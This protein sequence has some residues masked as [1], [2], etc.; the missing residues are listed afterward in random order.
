[1]SIKQPR[2]ESGYDQEELYF[3]RLNRNL[4][5]Q[6]KTEHQDLTA[7]SSPVLAQVIRLKP[8]A[9][10]YSIDNVPKKRAA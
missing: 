7:Q 1:M 9:E 6:I 5:Q 10:R 2:I 4:I 3:E 8:R